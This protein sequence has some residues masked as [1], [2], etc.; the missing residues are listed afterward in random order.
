[1]KKLVLLFLILATSIFGQ[2]YQIVIFRHGEKMAAEGFVG[3]MDALLNAQGQQRAA[4]LVNFLLQKQIIDQ[5]EH[6]IG[7]I[8]VPRSSVKDL[9]GTYNYVRCTQTIIP[10]FQEANA[11]LK[12]RVH[13]NV[14]IH[15]QFSFDQAHEVLAH[16]MK[17]PFERQTVVI[18]W[19][20]TEIPKLLTEQF[21]KLKISFPEIGK[22]IYDK[23]WVIRFE[24]DEP[25]G[26]TFTQVPADG[27][28]NP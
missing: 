15:N 10:L 4:Y 26:L 18:C 12:E 23:V 20:H 22:D 2:P 19:E 5:K 28:N 1:M 17:Q 21:E 16:L 14:A 25:T 8:Y 7:A 11:Y 27:F 9:R 24:G 3:D 13:K 6:P